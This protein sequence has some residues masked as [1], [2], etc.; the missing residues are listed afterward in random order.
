[1]VPYKITTNVLFLLIAPV[2]LC[3]GCKLKDSCALPALNGESQYAQL[4]STDHPDDSTYT[5]YIVNPWKQSQILTS[6]TTCP[7][8][9]F[10]NV[11]VTT[12]CHAALFSELGIA[13]RIAGICEIE[14]VSDSTVNSLY[15]QGK[16]ANCGS[17]MSPNIETIIDLNPDAIFVS[18]FE[19][20]NYGALEKLKIPLIECA[21]YM[22]TSPL[23][24][25]EWIPFFASLMG[26]PQK[27]DSLFNAVKERYIELCNVA[28][29]AKNIDGSPTVMT[30]MISSS[31]WYVP[32]GK[33][34]IGQLIQDAGGTYIFGY[35]EKNG[36]VPLS[37][38]T[39]LDQAQDADFWFIKNSTFSTV[40]YSSIEKEWSSYSLFKPF[41]QHNIWV[42]PVYQV[43]YF[44]QTAF[45]PEYL[46][47]EFITI[48]H[49]GLDIRSTHYPRY[50]T[51]LPT[52]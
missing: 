18:P 32:G 20:S 17:S 40:T 12:N 4:L 44:E 33:S 19:N 48:L 31:A 49:P 9:A 51:P 13:D 24:R 23:G 29:S 35:I 5:Y 27:G 7:A 36:S 43:P 14:Y 3:T 8:K 38:E 50:Y 1:M 25:A 45:H 21:D 2:L 42:C 28:D 52:Q 46:L 10:N 47:E 26:V 41:A 37:K 39:V 34:T 22:E 16:I 6:Y 30:D 15:N 11:I